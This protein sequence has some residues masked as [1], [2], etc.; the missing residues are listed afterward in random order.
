MENSNQSIANSKKSLFNIFQN[1]KLSIYKWENYFNIYEFYFNKFINKK[2]RVL[3][4]GIQY[5]GSLRMWEEYFNNAKIFG[6]DINP[7]CKKLEK[8][9]IDIQIGSQND[10]KFLKE[11]SKYV[12]NLDII[13]DDGGHTMDQQLNTFK[14]LFP[15]L[16]DGGIY[17]VEDIESS[18]LN[19]Y[20]G[21]FKRR[22]TFVEFSKNIID[23]INANHSDFLTLKP[24]WYSRNIE[25]IHFYNNVVVIKKKKIVEFPRHIRN[26]GK[27]SLDVNKRSKVPKLKLFASSIISLINKILGYIRLKPL[28]VGSTSQRL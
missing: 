11:Y 3:E 25:F 7:D 12:Q 14:E 28:Y 23:Y 27:L 22:G 15:I 20:G 1:S 8:E 19:M 21:G 26:D 13:I 5:G 17:V 9:N 24:N 16:N 18:Y 10:K 4:I 6:I 2:P